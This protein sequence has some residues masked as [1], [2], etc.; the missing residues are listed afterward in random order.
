MHLSNYVQEIKQVLFRVDVHAYVDMFR[1][2]Q[3]YLEK[4]SEHVYERRN[5][6]NGRSNR[7]DLV[8]MLE[9]CYSLDDATKIEQQF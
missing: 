6:S 4:L 3:T 5:M 9:F 2:N 8:G 7:W 1:N